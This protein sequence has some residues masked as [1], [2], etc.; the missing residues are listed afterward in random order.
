[1]DGIWCGVCGGYVGRR[2]RVICEEVVLLVRS[3]LF[4][5]LS[6]S[7]LVWHNHFFF[8][9]FFWLDLEFLCWGF[10]SGS[11]LYVFPRFLDY[12]VGI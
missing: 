10:F 7:L 4:F 1:M 12:L 2:G 9:F 3:G 5:F 8:F 11:V 6:F